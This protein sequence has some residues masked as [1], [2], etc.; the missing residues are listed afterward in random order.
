MNENKKVVID[1]YYSAIENLPYYRKQKK[2]LAVVESFGA[3]IWLLMSKRGVV[4]G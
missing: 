3:K 2:K 1:H 4:T